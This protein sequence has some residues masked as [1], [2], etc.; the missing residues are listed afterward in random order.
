MPFRAPVERRVRAYERFLDRSEKCVART[1]GNASPQQSNVVCEVDAETMLAPCV[2]TS[3]ARRKWP[4]L[5]L[6]S[7]GHRNLPWALTWS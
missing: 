2:D 5:D 3:L 1:A 6:R 7:V 4:V